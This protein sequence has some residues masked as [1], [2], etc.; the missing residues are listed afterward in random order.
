LGGA[1]RGYALPFTYGSAAMYNV[2][3]DWLPNRGSG[4]NGF[5][6]AFFSPDGRGAIP[7]WLI[8]KSGA[9]LNRNLFCTI[10]NSTRGIGY[11]EN[12]D[13]IG[14]CGACT[15]KVN[16]DEKLIYSPSSLVRVSRNGGVVGAPVLGE[17]QEKLNH[18]F[19]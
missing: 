3:N 14:K 9:F 16:M 1:V 13:Q 11:N 19:R 17:L 5:K 8:G 10:V 12:I 18:I 2:L 7:G 4:W 15:S 6:D